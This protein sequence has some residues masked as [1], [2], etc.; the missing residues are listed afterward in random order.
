MCLLK[1]IIIPTVIK[2]IFKSNITI[3]ATKVAAPRRVVN[4][5]NGK[6]TFPKLLILN[7]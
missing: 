7:F 6:A 2:K 3:S 4:K 1:K 5:T